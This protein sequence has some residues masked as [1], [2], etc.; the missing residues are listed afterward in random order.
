[1]KGHVAKSLKENYIKHLRFSGVDL[2]TNK[3]LLANE[4]YTH[5]HCKENLK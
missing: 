4:S 3:G 1:M 2:T 5:N